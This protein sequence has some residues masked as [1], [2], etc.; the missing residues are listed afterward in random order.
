MD[1]GTWVNMDPLRCNYV[2]FISWGELFRDYHLKILNE[3][4]IESESWLN[5]THPYIA[6][7]FIDF[8]I[9]TEK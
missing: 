3:I 5:E 4:S 6:C 2:S 8:C 7:E 9:D 1:F